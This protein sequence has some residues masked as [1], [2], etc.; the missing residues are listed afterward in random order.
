MGWRNRGGGW[1][2]R[3]GSQQPVLELG[4]GQEGAT[5]EAAAE[6]LCGSL[7]RCGWRLR[8]GSIWARPRPGGPRSLLALA[9]CFAPDLGQ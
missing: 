4:D 2:L 6:M 8:A 3:I 1:R 7:G 9:S 5:M